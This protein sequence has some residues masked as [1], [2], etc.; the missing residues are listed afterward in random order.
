M[1]M[2]CYRYAII[3][4]IKDYGKYRGLWKSFMKL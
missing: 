1:Q 2:Q 4:N 3:E